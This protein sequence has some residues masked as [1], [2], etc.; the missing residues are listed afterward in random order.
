MAELF[1]KFRPSKWLSTASKAQLLTHEEKGLFIDLIAMMMTEEIKVL[2]KSEKTEKSELPKVGN[3]FFSDF[4]LPLKLKTE[5]SKFELLISKLICFG[6]VFVENGILRSKFIDSCLLEIKSRSEINR[7]N[8]M[9]GGRPKKP[10]NQDK[11]KDKDIKEKINKKES[12]LL[13]SETV[14]KSTLPEDLKSKFIEWLEVRE[15]AHGSMPPRAQ[16]AQ[17]AKLLRL[18]EERRYIELENAIGGMWKNISD[19]R[20]MPEVPP[21][22][23]QEDNGNKDRIRKEEY[24]RRYGHL[25]RQGDEA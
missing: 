18:P 9:R 1:L 6:L 5:K 4:T 11:D 21:M 15:V 8:G 22:S 25:M 12:E 23:N 17:L 3:C 20:T 16:D 14:T 19:T 7:E 24:Q 10:K 2:S 13:I